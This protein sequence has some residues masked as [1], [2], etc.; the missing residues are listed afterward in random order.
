MSTFETVIDNRYK[1]PILSKIWSPNNKIKTMRQLWIDLAIIQ[2]ELGIQYITDEAIKELIEARDIVDLDN[3]KSYEL[4]LNHDIMA[5]IRAYSDLCP[6]G[7]KIIHLGATSNFINDNVDSIL[8]KSSF[9][10]I[11]SKVKSFYEI[12]TPFNISNA[13]KLNT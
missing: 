7:G 9:A 11:E 5:H 10:I 1:A 12:L 8:V 13:Y 6:L 2:K 4:R 3:I